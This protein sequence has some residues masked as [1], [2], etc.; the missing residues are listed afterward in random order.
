MGGWW[1]GGAGK[2][3]A[4]KHNAIIEFMIYTIAQ[5]HFRKETWDTSFIHTLQKKKK[6][7]SLQIYNNSNAIQKKG[8]GGSN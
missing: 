5:Y 6:K 8:R 2:N 1:W 4:A 3:N 7:T